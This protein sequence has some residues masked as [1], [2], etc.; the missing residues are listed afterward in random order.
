MRMN[1][2]NDAD[3]GQERERTLFI[4]FLLLNNCYTR[5]AALLLV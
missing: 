5:A 2:L 3:E 1:G 4:K